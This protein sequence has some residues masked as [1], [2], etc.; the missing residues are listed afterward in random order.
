MKAIWPFRHFGLK[1]LSL[2]LALL[3]WMSVAGEEIVER[4]LR[5]PLELQ[6][7]PSGLELQGEPPA[8]VDVR[9]RG[10][11]A[12]LS[13][14]GAGDVYA[15]LD[16]H[17]ASPGR[18]LFHLTPEQ[19]RAPFGVDVVQIN[20]AT[21]ALAFERS[22]SKQVK[23]TPSIDG[24]PAPGYVLGMVSVDP[25]AVDVVGPESAVKRVEDAFTEPVT[26]TGARDRVREIVTLGL[27]D[28]SL[29]LKGARTAT[30]TVQVLPGPVERTFRSVAIH[31]RNLGEGLSAEAQP[32]T[33]NVTVRGSRDVNRLDPDEVNVFVDL[34]GLGAG[35][36]TV[37]AHGFATQ[38]AGVIRID[39]QTVQVHITSGRS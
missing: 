21:V 38:E 5:V 3:L 12:A 24:V 1:V 8:A 36:Y 28:P 19:V 29:R 6:Q 18:R 15:V 26:V 35:H 4:G 32:A 39:P 37:T 17:G 22:A 25:S 16:L 23:V 14:V 2:G 31:L 34:S 10:A 33:V 27:F 7:F 11:S 9:V 30:V 13:R 20:P